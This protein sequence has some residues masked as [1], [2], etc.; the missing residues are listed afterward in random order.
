MSRY[1]SDPRYHRALLRLLEVPSSPRLGLA[2]M[3]ELLSRLDDPHRQFS[4]LHVAGTNGKGSIVAYT[5]ALLGVLG[6]RRGRTTSPH[7][8][9]AVE[10]IAIDGEPISPESFVAL[11]EQIHRAAAAMDDAP[12][13]FERVI[14]MAFLAFAEAGVEVA[15]VEVGLGG[16]LDATNVLAP[17]AMALSRIGLDHTQFLG[18]TLAAIAREKAGILKPGRP[19]ISAPQAPEVSCVFEEIAASV[20]ARLSFLEEAD[21]QWA[22]AQPRGFG[23][24]AMSAEAAAMACALVKN[25]GYAL[26]EHQRRAGLAAARWPGRYEKVST[27][28]LVLLDGAHNAHGMAALLAEL[29]GD[30]DT[31]RPAHVVF[32]MTRGHTATAVARELASLPPVSVHVV[33]A[34]APRSR[35]GDEL[36]AELVEAGL[37]AEPVG[38][39]ER[40]LELALAA[41]RADGGFVLVTGSLYLVGEVRALFLP[42]PTDPVLPEF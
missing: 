6:R 37:P 42:M 4:S 13:F 9:S 17:E 22:A 32:G 26:E 41:A 21:L 24:G 14:A 35:V 39:V 30:P 5:D 12:T 34:R 36:A 16:R 27:E 11:E 2:R 7:L 19:A 8:L 38:E 18:D 31:Q 23:H 10:R 15:V 29:R 40:G 33:R 25:A 3:L 20:G 28:P 1:P